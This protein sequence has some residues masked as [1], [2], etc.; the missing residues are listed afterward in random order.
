MKPTQVVIKGE[1]K[2]KTFGWMSWR[3]PKRG[4]LCDLTNLLI[5]TTEDF[6]HTHRQ[7]HESL[8]DGSFIKD[9]YFPSVSHNP[10][11]S[12][13]SH[14][15]TKKESSSRLPSSS[16][17]TQVRR[18][19][20]TFP[21]CRHKICRCDHSLGRPR[22]GSCSQASPNYWVLRANGGD[23]RAQVGWNSNM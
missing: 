14:K 3:Q 6:Q 21:L 11:K 19:H 4:A 12:L 2:Q 18:K 16:P 22:R 9:G 20:R 13:E 1:K 23:F 7:N 5:F 10:L 8:Y 17:S 15:H